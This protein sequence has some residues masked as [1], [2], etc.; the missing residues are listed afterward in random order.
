MCGLTGFYLQSKK[1]DVRIKVS[2]AVA[3][4]QMLNEQ[5]GGDSW[6]YFNGQE[7]QKDTGGLGSIA[8]D[9]LMEHRFALAHTRMATTGAKTKRNAH[10]FDV[11]G[12]TAH[13][14]GAH[15]GVVSNY[16]SIAKKNGWTV[17]VDSEVIF[18]SLANG[19][20]LGDLNGYGTITWVDMEKPDEVMLCR[21]SDSAQLAIAVLGSL[22]KAEAVIWSSDEAHLRKALG[23]VGMKST[24][25]KVDA[26]NVYRID[27]KGVWITEEK[28]HIGIQSYSQNSYVPARTYGGFN[29][30]YH[31][32][33]R[34]EEDT[35]VVSSRDK[36]KNPLEEPSKIEL[37]ASEIG[38]QKFLDNDHLLRL[39]PEEQKVVLKALG[40]P[41][42]P[43]LANKPEDKKD[44][45]TTDSSKALVVVPEPVV[46]LTLPVAQKTSE[47]LNSIGFTQPNPKPEEKQMP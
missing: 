37:A 12:S 14:I 20:S 17:E 46:D 39:K 28:H 16:D 2:R 15:N 1:A 7:V 41:L 33:D 18:Q 29:D 19:K 11:E 44:A 6:G 13:I 26:H 45:V 42:P 30:N 27:N 36:S 3:M 25:L 5:R 21:M 35:V 47:V 43:R 22:D 10:P 38:L 8:T 31:G 9:N 34:D 4:L 24:M 40:F 23:I 32:Y